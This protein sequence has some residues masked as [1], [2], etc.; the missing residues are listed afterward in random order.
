MINIVVLWWHSWTDFVKKCVCQRGEAVIVN[1]G[2]HNT[3]GDR[4]Q[5]GISRLLVCAARISSFAVPPHSLSWH[6]NATADSM[7]GAYAERVW[8]QL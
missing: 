5:D 3:A 2:F 8:H 4:A 6:M 1:R 7:P